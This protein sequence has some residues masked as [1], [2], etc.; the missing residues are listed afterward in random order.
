MGRHDSD[1]DIS[2]PRLGA[3]Q[4]RL[5]HD[6]DDDMSPPRPAVSA[7]QKGSRHDSDDDISP[8][9]AVG[10]EKTIPN[11]RNQRASGKAVVHKR[12]DSDSDI[13][14]PRSATHVHRE[15]S[16]PRQ[17]KGSPM[18]MSS[19]LKSGLVLGSDMKKEAAELRQKQREAL[20][21]AP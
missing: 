14:P 12:H 20:E 10:R 5:R 15:S 3:P 8:P 2:P 16:P 6:S 17:R 1:D 19:G 13:S 9:R 18:R 7:P 21:V 4:Q 11:T